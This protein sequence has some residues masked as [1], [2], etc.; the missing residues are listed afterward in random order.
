M[1]CVYSQNIFDIDL[2]DYMGDINH[3]F[4][5]DEIRSVW[6]EEGKRWMYSIVDVVG[7]LS[8]SKN[9]FTYWRVLKKRLND[10]GNETVTNCN[11]LKMKASDGRM[12]LTDVADLEQILQIVQ[13]IPSRRADSFKQWITKN[14]QSLIDAQSKQKARQL[15]DTGAIDGMEIGTV[16][17]LIQI[18]KYLFGGIYPFAGQVREQNIRKGGFKFANALYLNDTLEAIERMPEATFE[19]I[20]KKYVEMNVAHPFL[21][22]NGRS[23]RIW[24]D[25]ILKKNL[26]K[27]IDW[28]RID[29]YDYLSAMQGSVSED[30]VIMEL[31]CVA[32]TD[33]IDDREIFMKGIDQSYYYEEFEDDVQAD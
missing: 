11:A 14:A 4:Q 12:R 32:L 17:G 24:L 28:Q 19:E 7:A 16:D 21:E 1:D 10:E 2:E 6:D 13:C 18:H 30:T 20:V 9:P 27:C 26:K 25:L 5:G 15:F 31:L 8:E 22:G 23:T 29:K 33:K 3:I